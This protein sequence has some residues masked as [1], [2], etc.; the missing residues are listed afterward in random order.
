MLVLKLCQQYCPE[1]IP[2]KVGSKLGDGSDGEVFNVEGQPD[3]VIKFSI[4]LESQIEPFSLE[5]KFNNIR[6]VLEFLQNNPQENFARVYNH[7]WM[8]QFSRTVYGNTQ[9]N[10]FLYYYIMEKLQK[11]SDD[12]RKLFH[13][14]L[15]HEDRKINK[16]YSTLQIKK[17]LT[18]LARGLDFDAEKVTLFC[19]KLRQSPVLHLDIDARNIMKNISGQFRLV[20]FDRTLLRRS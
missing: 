9:E 18:G 13:S 5:N 19:D 11:I 17:M 10:Y 2:V 8:G 20:D 7:Q 15:S 6:E 1:L 14:I 12:E 4:M 16:N 3:K